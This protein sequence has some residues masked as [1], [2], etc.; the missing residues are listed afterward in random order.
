MKKLSL[1]WFSRVMSTTSNIIKIM[2]KI[3]GISSQSRTKPI[4]KIEIVRDIFTH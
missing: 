4:D 1:A 3:V 2:A